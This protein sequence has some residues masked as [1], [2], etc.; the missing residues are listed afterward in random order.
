MFR[1]SRFQGAS[2]E[3]VGARPRAATPENIGN[4]LNHI[5]TMFAEHKIFKQ[6]YNTS[7][8]YNWRAVRNYR[9]PVR[10]M[11]FLIN[12]VWDFPNHYK[13]LAN[14]GGD[15]ATP[16][17]IDMIIDE[18]SRFAENE[19]YHTN[20]IGVRYRSIFNSTIDTNVQ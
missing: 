20:A 18:T 16:D 2:G 12:E 14:T 7:I 11:R 9:A 4:S 13:S 3:C 17:M 1:I 8:K 6:C 5:I 10:D 19:V 15:M